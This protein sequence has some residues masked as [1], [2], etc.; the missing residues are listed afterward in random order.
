M[1][2]A[3]GPRPAPAAPWVSP[4]GPSLELKGDHTMARLPAIDKAKLSPDAQAIWDKIL[5]N[6]SGAAMR[7]PSATLM[8][9]PTLADRVFT[10]E[11]YF[12]GPEAD[13]PGVDRELVIMATAREMGAKF[14]WARHE[15]RGHELGT[16]KE[17]I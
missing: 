3:T 8:H 17:A 16:R 15:A 14:A 2:P 1:C 5:A 7:G 6:R 13:L 10:L 9:V 4:S 11:D 12:R